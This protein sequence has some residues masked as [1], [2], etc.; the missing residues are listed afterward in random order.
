VRLATA[1]NNDGV[2]EMW[3]DGVKTINNTTLP[4]YPDYGIGNYMRNGYLMG[5]ANSGF[6]ATSNTYIDDVIISGV[7]I[8]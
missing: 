7:P 5:W 2:I 8:P 6:S 4:L 1:A 3:V